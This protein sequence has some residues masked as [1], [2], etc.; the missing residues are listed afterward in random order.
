MVNLMDSPIRFDNSYRKI[1]SLLNLTAER[2]NVTE[3]GER[4]A[5][6][7][8]NL[9]QSEVFDLTVSLFQKV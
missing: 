2:L 6:H 1:A 4:Q 8:C 5:C 9:L 7:C 3:I